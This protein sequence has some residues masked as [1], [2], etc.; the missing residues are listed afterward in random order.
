MASGV[1][2]L[3]WATKQASD[4]AASPYFTEVNV[5]VEQLIHKSQGMEACQ[6]TF[7]NVSGTNCTQFE[8]LVAE[9]DLHSD[10]PVPPT[11]KS[12]MPDPTV[13]TG[14]AGLE[15]GV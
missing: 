9:I 1:S 6:A 14:R 11:A 2:I 7:V 5:K 12:L 3:L 15:A 8:G 10:D 4:I 13:T